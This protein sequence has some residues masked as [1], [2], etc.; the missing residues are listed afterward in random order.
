V[1]LCLLCTP[2]PPATH[3]S[4]DSVAPQQL[5]WLLAWC[6]QQHTRPCPQV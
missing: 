2:L 1:L 6:H 4:V 3:D 5:K